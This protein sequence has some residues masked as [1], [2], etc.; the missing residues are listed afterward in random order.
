MKVFCIKK[1]L[2]LWERWRRSRR[3]GKISPLTRSRGSSPRGR[4][5]RYVQLYI[6][7]FCSI[8]LYRKKVTSSA[9]DLG[10]RAPAVR[11][12]LVF[13][14]ARTFIFTPRFSYTVEKLHCGADRVVVPSGSRQYLVF[15][16]A[17][18][19]ISTPRFSYTARK[20]HCGADR[21]VVPSGLR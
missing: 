13:C 1:S 18:T 4:A 7:R 21:V 12:N 17:K 5:F 8:W 16:S 19:F 9:E 2:A 11:L 14:T 20:L 10:W 15:C 3:R 6:R